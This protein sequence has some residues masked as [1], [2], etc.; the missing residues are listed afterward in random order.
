MNWFLLI[1]LSLTICGQTLALFKGKSHLKEL[2]LETAETG[3]APVLS[4]DNHGLSAYGKKAEDYESYDRGDK[5]LKDYYGDSGYGAHGLNKYSDHHDSGHYNAKS[6]S[7]GHNY[8]QGVWTRNRGY[9]YEKHY[10]YDKELS[11]SKYGGSHSD[12]KSSLGAHDKSATDK[13][14]SYDKYGYNKYGGHAEHDSRDYGKYGHLLDTYGKKSYGESEQRQPAPVYQ[15]PAPV[16]V[17]AVPQHI[18]A[19]PQHIVQYVAA[20]PPP[21]KAVT[22]VY[23]TQGSPHYTPALPNP[24]LYQTI[25]DAYSQGITYY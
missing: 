12:H 25:G 23:H 5:G 10:A 16:Y 9:G 1:C 20:P 22:K 2:E 14:S 15:V 18:P 17:E 24:T 8:G 4:Y 6:G 7:E 21:A 19:P 3:Y 11:T 13:L